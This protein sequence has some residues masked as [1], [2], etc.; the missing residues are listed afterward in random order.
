MSSR[1]RRPQRVADL[2]TALPEGSPRRR[3]RLYPVVDDGGVLRGV[4]P[5]SVVLEAKEDRT[6][7]A[8]DAMMEP[9]AIA[10]PDEILRGVADR[11]AANGLGVLPV[12]DRGVSCRLRGLISQFD[13]L[14]A[15]QKLLE[16]E[17]HAE[18]VLTLRRPVPVVHDPE[19]APVDGLMDSEGT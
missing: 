2:Y 11:M 19:P 15:R 18:R 8:T 9:V 10:Y 6:R 16:E 3:Q 5:W 1:W 4:L 14:S 13:L 7:L 12:V 17:R